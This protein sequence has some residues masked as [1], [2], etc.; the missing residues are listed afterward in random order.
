M[1]LSRQ[2]PEEPAS[3]ILRSPLGSVAKR[4]NL[5]HLLAMEVVCTQSFG[6]VENNTVSPPAT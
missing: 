3:A 4:L 6:R 1:R 5:L 2:N